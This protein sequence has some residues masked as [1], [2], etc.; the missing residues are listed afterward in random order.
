LNDSIPKYTA[1]YNKSITVNQQSLRASNTAQQITELAEE[2]VVAIN[3]MLSCGCINEFK[4]N[5]KKTKDKNKIDSIVSDRL[6]HKELT[7][8]NVIQQH[9]I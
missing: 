1:V 6:N 2:Y 8:Y 3:T 4:E 9:P 7:N 5:I